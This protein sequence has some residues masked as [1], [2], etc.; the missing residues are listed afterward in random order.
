MLTLLGSLPV[1][2]CEGKVKVYC[3]QLTARNNSL[4]TYAKCYLTLEE[5]K[6]NSESGA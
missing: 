5:M 1:L 4:Q 3:F 2:H 6:S